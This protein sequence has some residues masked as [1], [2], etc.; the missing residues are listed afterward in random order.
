MFRVILLAFISKFSYIN[1]L[2][3]S[4]N[5]KTVYNLNGIVYLLFSR[6]IMLKISLHKGSISH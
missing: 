4:K 2:I 6:I 3:P 1:T 5:L